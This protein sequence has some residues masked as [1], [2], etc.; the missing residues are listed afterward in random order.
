MAGSINIYKLSHIKNACMHRLLCTYEI[1]LL[2]V[3]SKI[4]IQPFKTSLY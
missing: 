2:D 3:T 4:K 1:I